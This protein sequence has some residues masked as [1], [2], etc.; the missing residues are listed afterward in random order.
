MV[1]G[2]V[3]VGFVVAGLVVVTCVVEG[4]FVVAAVVVAGLVVA[5]FVV[6]A[7]LVVVMFC[8]VDVSGSG[9][10]AK[11]QAAR[12]LHSSN[13]ITGSQILFMKITPFVVRF[14][15]YYS[16][17]FLRMQWNFV[18]KNI[19]PVQTPNWWTLRLGCTNCYCKGA[20]GVV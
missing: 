11:P 16:I 5:A 12:T 4:A 19:C 20:C 3:V 13:A 1:V 10:C 2:L 8:V 7:V 17:L 18:K 9:D 6:V 14:R 15:P